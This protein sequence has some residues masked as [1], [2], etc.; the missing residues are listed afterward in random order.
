MPILPPPSAPLTTGPS[1]ARLQL[2]ARL[3]R[4][5]EA[6]NEAGS[7][8][9]GGLQGQQSHSDESRGKFPISSA[10]GSS[11]LPQSY[12]E[13]SSP[14][15]FLPPAHAVPSG[16][17]S[18]SSSD[19]S[20]EIGG[21]ERQ[22]FDMDDFDDDDEDIGDMITP[23]GG[24][25]STYDNDEEDSDD[26]LITA[27]LG[28]SSFLGNSHYLSGGSKGAS[29]SEDMTNSSDEEDDGLVEIMVPGKSRVTS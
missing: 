19:G 12:V 22:G 17:L 21:S 23:A 4:Q 18:S 3:A 28:Y 7:D 1:R 29:L 20:V 11:A 27:P 5:H 8:D 16:Y 9:N 2:A 14:P 10:A 24:I 26:G 13:Y 6:N 25:A 15:S